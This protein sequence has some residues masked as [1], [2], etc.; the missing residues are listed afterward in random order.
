MVAQSCCDKCDRPGSNQHGHEGSIPDGDDH[1]APAPLGGCI[2]AGA[3]VEV[4]TAQ[5]LV[6]H[7]VL[8][9]AHWVPPQTL[10]SGFDRPDIVSSVLLPDDDMNVGRA[11]RCLMMSLLC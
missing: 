11:K 8:S 6:V 7:D 1:G 2:C 10:D 3:V 4:S 9:V 5:Q